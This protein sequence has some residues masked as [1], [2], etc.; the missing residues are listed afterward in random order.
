MGKDAVNNERTKQV[1]TATP[2]LSSQITRVVIQAGVLA[3][4]HR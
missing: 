2:H 1:H 3:L 4:D